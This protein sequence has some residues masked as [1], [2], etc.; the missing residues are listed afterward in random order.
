[1]LVLLLYS[2]QLSWLLPTWISGEL[3]YRRVMKE[4]ELEIPKLEAL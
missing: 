1:M 2:H 4:G 3:N